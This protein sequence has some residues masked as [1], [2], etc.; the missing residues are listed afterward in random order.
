[1]SIPDPPYK[2]RKI[3]TRRT[4]ERLKDDVL[5][6]AEARHHIK[7]YSGHTHAKQVMH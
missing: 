7:G 1:M 2:D 4:F 3:C 5:E 6:V